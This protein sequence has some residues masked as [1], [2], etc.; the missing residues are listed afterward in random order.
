VFHFS[1]EGFFSMASGGDV[2]RGECVRWDC[3]LG[4]A[5][6]V[7]DFGQNKLEVEVVASVWS[8]LQLNFLTSR[9]A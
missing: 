4:F 7:F 1:D 5:T 8:H 3:C 2:R 9:I 6:T